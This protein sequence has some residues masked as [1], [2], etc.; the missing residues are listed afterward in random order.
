MLMECIFI[1]SVYLI[2]LIGSFF[3]LQVTSLRAY[4]G[5]HPG[6]YNLYYAGAQSPSPAVMIIRVVSIVPCVMLV[7]AR[8]VL[9]IFIVAAI[10][11]ILPG[12]HTA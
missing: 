1:L 3:I 8:V 5:H 12:P 7:L 9:V 6:E 4:S 10:P 11:F 2:S